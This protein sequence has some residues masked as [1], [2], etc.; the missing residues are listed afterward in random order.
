V[1]QLSQAN[2]NSLSNMQFSALLFTLVSV[3]HVYAEDFTYGL[4]DPHGPSHWGDKQEDQLCKTGQKQSPVNIF[5]SANAAG[6]V[7]TYRWVDG[8]ANIPFHHNGHSVEAD[9][10]TFNNIV[11][12]SQGGVS[13]D[14][15]VAQFHFHSPSEHQIMS[16]SADAEVHFVAKPVGAAPQG[17]PAAIVTAVLYYRSPGGA[18]SHLQKS[19]GFLR[20][21]IDNIPS[22]TAN[23]KTIP[24]LNLLKF[25]TKHLKNVNNVYTY[26]GSL[27]TPPC[28]EGIKWFV[29]MDK[30]VIK[31][32]DFTA[33]GTAI[34]FQNARPVTRTMH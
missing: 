9:L 19:A 29:F 4:N 25:A 27:T 13:H 28:S 7:P 22:A 26:D 18:N 34:G 6:N 31:S 8:L 16:K 21:V 17:F 1:F 2:F 12:Y 33:L 10:S 11:S 24:A 30:A 3:S 32:N 23:Q 14:Y 5:A 15:K 20:A